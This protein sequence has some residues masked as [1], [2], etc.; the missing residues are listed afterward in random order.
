M[1]IDTRRAA[2]LA[3]ALCLATLG[4]AIAPLPAT[5]D[6][7]T[8]DKQQT[9]ITF[10]WGHLGI[11]RQS[12]RLLDV[13]GT[14][15]FDPKE[16]EKGAVDVTMKV[17][18]LWTG[19]GELDRQLKSS[20]YFDAAQFPTMTF[21]STGVRAIGDKTGEVTGDLTILGQARPVTLL[22][23]WNFSGEHPLSTL[24]PAFKDKF[25]S[26]FTATSKLLRSE[27]GMTRGTPLTTDEIE[28]TI[29]TELIRKTASQ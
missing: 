7:Y 10:S 18:S 22:V 1:S 21:K 2:A 11:S 13:S 15:E 26:G 19:V 23:T 6:T 25:V 28:I 27:W 12:A 8:F 29:N 3:T 20:D 5:A 9:N 14:V 24:N 16:P 4:F 17:A